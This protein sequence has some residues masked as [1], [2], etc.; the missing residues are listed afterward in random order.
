MERG[1]DPVTRE[2]VEQAGLGGWAVSDSGLSAT[3]DCVSFTAAGR[4]A[5][6]IAALADDR[7]HHPDLSLTYPGHLHIVTISH[8]VR[9]L[10][11]RDLGLATAVHRLAEESGCSVVVEGGA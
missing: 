4:F 6:D 5:A 3:Y 9:R 2:S 8:D 1:N 7:D 10:T 11:K